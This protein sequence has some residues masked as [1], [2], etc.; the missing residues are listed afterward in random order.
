[1]SLKVENITRSHQSQPQETCRP[2]P[3]TPPND[4][5]AKPYV[6]RAERIV[7]RDPPEALREFLGP[8]HSIPQRGRR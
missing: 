4:E 5:Y 7:E 2:I 1:M 8:R 3:R 6:D